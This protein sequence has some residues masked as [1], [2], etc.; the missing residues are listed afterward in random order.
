MICERCD[1][2]G[3]LLLKDLTYGT[4][5]LSKGKLVVAE[6]R[7]YPVL[8]AGNTLPVVIVLKS[9]QNLTSPRRRL[10]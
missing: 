7:Q 3:E 6:R 9:W 4:I 1:S 5:G 8:S 2:W 10:S